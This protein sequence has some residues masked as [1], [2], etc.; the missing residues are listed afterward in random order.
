MVAP[1]IVG[2]GERAGELQWKVGILFL[3]PIWVEEGRRGE[4]HVELLTAGGNGG[5]RL[6]SE[7]REAQSGVLGRERE[8]KRVR[9]LRCEANEGG[10]SCAGA[11]P[12]G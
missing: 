8:W 11:G 10:D 7:S 4:L 1:V 9:R 6:V 12:R 2:C 5:L 3:R